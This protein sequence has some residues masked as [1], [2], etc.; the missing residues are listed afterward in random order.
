MAL[1][2]CY[3]CIKYL[4]FAFNFIFWV[5]G[6]AIL[7][8][9]I[10]LRVDE[11]AMEMMS[12]HSKLD[13]L[14]TLAYCMMAV[15]FIVMMVGFLG[16][17]GAIRES[18]CMLATFFIA[19]FVIFAI[20]LGL[21]IWAVV[22][23]GSLEDMIEGWLDDGVENYSSLTNDVQKNF[24][25]GIQDDLECCGSA[26]GKADYTDRGDKIPTTCYEHENQPCLTAVVQWWEDKMV[27]IAGVSIGIS[28]VMI[29]GMIFAIVLCCAVRDTLA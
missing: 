1:G 10:W 20:L 22:A 23:K 28:V 12:H 29:L 8:I 24:M 9:G 14:Y 17:C 2:S 25:D 7:G 5:L 4:M 3:S 18:Q 21:G 27:T 13:L 11:T 26:K 6:C 19:L 16:C 15:G